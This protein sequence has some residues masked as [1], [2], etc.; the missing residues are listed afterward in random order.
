M[1][2]LYLAAEIA[3]E[4]NIETKRICQLLNVVSSQIA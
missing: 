2:L 4:A 1:R 3:E